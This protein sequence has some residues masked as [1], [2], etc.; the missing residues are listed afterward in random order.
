[1]T[2]WANASVVANEIFTDTSAAI[3]TLAIVDVSTLLLAVALFLDLISMFTITCVCGRF[4]DQVNACTLFATCVVLAIVHVAT[5]HIW[6]GGAEFTGWKA[7]NIEFCW[8]V[9]F[10]A[11]RETCQ[12]LVDGLLFKVQGLRAAF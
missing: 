6:C 12:A 10:S 2:G 4:P 9:R 3:F 8:S 1:M 11:S 5:L 7:L